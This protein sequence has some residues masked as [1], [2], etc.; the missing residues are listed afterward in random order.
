MAKVHPIEEHSELTGI[1]L[2]G[3]RVGRNERK[4]KTPTLEAL[5]PKNEVPLFQ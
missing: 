2:D 1:E 5:V 4:A 3:L